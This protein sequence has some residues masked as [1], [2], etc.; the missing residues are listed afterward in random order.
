MNRRSLLRLAA[1]LVAAAGLLA[2]PT[3]ALAL[4]SVPD[5][6][7]MTNGRVLA[8]AQKG[9]TLYIGGKFTKILDQNGKVQYAAQNVAAIDMT[10]GQGI[11]SFSASVTN[12]S[13]SAAEVDALAVSS[14]GSDVYIGG[15]FDTVNG[16]SHKRFAAVSSSTGALDARFAPAFANGVRT[17]LVTPSLVYVGGQFVSV[18]GKSRQRLAA[19]TSTG[20]LDNTWVPFANSMVRKLVLAPDG[21][22]I[23][24]AGA[25]STMDGV[26]RQSV[27]R[28]TTDTGALDAWAIP[29]G[30]IGNPMTA[31]D[32][33]P[34]STRLY[35]GFGA[36]PNYLSA[37]HLDMGSYGGQ[38]WK[39][40]FVGNVQTVALSP[41]GSRLFFGGHM[42][43]ATLQQSV[44]GGSNNLH[45]LGSVN[46]STGAFNCD[47]YP[48]ILPDSGNY[49]AAWTF[50]STPSALWIGGYFT[51]VGGKTQ[52]G[53]A[54]YSY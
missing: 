34:T 39:D 6:T 32:L 13:G 50:L 52:K 53:L 38:I 8:M 18:N 3:A 51:S 49:T 25:F 9:T 22:T 19:L 48:T 43:T 36:K 42:G 24:V 23:F 1:P 7:W 35:V 44:C 11:P 27:A 31:W 54:R 30:T 29:T 14:D 45:G 12:A 5:S 20:K 46:P 16:V 17:I 40:N 26:S 15:L 21:K 10:T 41:D 33:L 47:W 37:F 28:V 2:A 4:S